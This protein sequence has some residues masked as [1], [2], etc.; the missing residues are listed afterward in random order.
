MYKFVKVKSSYVWKRKLIDHLNEIYTNDD[1]L[2]ARH[3]R[4][5][6]MYCSCH[7][8]VTRPAHV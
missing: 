4:I 5:C 7:G 6:V 8:L 1:G 3:S 2:R